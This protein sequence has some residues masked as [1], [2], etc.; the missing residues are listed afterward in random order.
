[1]TVQQNRMFRE[2]LAGM[3]Y[4]RNIR[5]NHLYPSYLNSSHSSHVQ[6][7]CFTS[8]EAYLRATRKNC[9]VFNCLKSSHSL[10]HTQPLQINPK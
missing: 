4:P 10:S 6:G 8:R 7:T 3:P 9:L 2:Y 1:M 5:E